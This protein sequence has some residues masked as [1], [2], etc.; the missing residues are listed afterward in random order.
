MLLRCFFINDLWFWGFFT[1]KKENKKRIS[2]WNSEKFWCQRASPIQKETEV[3]RLAKQ[4]LEII[5]EIA[6]KADGGKP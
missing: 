1:Q 6:T 2:V 4:F 5:N 3:E